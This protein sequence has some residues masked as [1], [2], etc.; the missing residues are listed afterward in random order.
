MKGGNMEIGIRLLK[1]ITLGQIKETDALE[2][3][4]YNV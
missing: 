2:A 1:Q 4:Y 3:K